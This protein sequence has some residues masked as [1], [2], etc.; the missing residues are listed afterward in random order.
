MSA[1]GVHRER[2]PGWV[3]VDDGPRLPRTHVGKDGWGHSTSRPFALLPAVT[4]LLAG[5]WG[6]PLSLSLDLALLFLSLA[7]SP[8]L[9]G[10][11]NERCPAHL[12]TR[13][14]EATVKML[15]RPGGPGGI[16]CKIALGPDGSTDLHDSR[17]G[18]P[19]AGPKIRSASPLWTARVRCADS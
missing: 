13:L 12:L 6:W 5:E 1:R 15:A 17:Q 7:R 14:V 10:P 16:A 2:P 9:W 19:C 18:P 8:P 3:L 11:T 4:H